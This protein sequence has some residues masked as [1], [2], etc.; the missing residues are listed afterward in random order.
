MSTLIAVTQYSTKILARAYK[1]LKE[2]NGIQI[3]EEKVHK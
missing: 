1:Q 3:I 2:I